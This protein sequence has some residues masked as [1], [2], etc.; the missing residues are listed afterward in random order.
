[1][2]KSSKKRT[3]HDDSEHSNYA[4][5]NGRKGQASSNGRKGPQ[6]QSL[7]AFF[8]T[9]KSK[10]NSNVG[11][12]GG[13]DVQWREIGGTWIGKWG[14]PAPATKF[15]AFDLDFTL[16][17]VAGN[18]RFP[19][20]A[21]DWRFFHADAPTV[22]RRMHQ[23]G[24]KIVILSNQYGLRPGKKDVGLS[25]KAI[26]YRQKISNIA[27]QLQVPF[28]ILAAI[29]KDYMCKPSPGM[30]HMARL[31]N[32]G[33]DVDVSSSFFVGDA[34][35]R[36]DGWKAGVAADF[37]DSDLAFAL[38]VGVP[39]YTPEEV[40]ADSVCAKEEPLPLPAPQPWAVRRFT[41]K[42]LAPNHDAHAEL[43]ASIAKHA[44]EAKGAN[45][46]LAV[47]LVG[48]PGCGKSKFTQTHLVP[49]GFERVNMDEMQTRKKCT[50]FVR[51][52]LE[53]NGLVAI[54]NTNPDPESRKQF[55]A[56]ADKNGATCIAVVFEHTTRDLAMHNNNF[57]AQLVQAQ[58]FA[59]EAPSVDLQKRLL[60]VPVCGDRVP[61]VAYH[62]FFKRL[63]A[64][65]VTEGFAEVLTHTF[66]P[67]FESTDEELL[68]HQYY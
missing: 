32:E 18:G 33:I 40:F 59:D 31:D 54:D 16:I 24:Y 37:S 62:A 44:D 65:E 51:Q 46:G 52:R 43:L 35:G 3:M 55:L 56:I 12:I 11:N 22:L 42:L 10:A 34:A 1:M 45:R 47:L 23:Q 7:G 57:R 64:P 53:S 39:F 36:P 20:N 14:N 6:Q 29:S 61:D 48:P 9:K 41:P 38:N 60:R 49:L 4:N 27:K 25:K 26:E 21:D 15:A 8:T 2:S 28:T 50:D 5:S 19:R 17:R 58:Y 13:D 67:A 30:W 68:W 66:V 63:Q